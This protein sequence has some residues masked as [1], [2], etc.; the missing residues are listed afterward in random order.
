MLLVGNG[1]VLTLDADM[2]CIENGCVAIRGDGVIV[3]VGRTE[4]LRAAHPDAAFEDARGRVIMPGWINVHQH[5]YSAFAR[6]MSLGGPPQHDFMQVLEGLWWRMDKGL[7]LRDVTD[8]AYVTGI[9]CIRNGVTT[10]FDHH[11]SPFAAEGSLFAIGEVVRALGLRASLAIEVSDRDGPEIARAEIDENLAWLDACRAA[12]SDRLKGLF[13]L[14]ALFTL[15]DDT[16]AYC[17]ERIDPRDGY[18]VHVAEGVLDATQSLQAHQMQ[19]TERLDRFGILRPNTLAVHCIAVT[20]EGLDLLAARDVCVAHNPQSN[21]NNAAG[22]ARILDM[23]RR[24]I[25]AGLGTDGYTNDVLASYKTAPVLQ[26]HCLQDPSV[27]F[28]ETA[29]ML[30]RGNAQIAMRSFE[31]PMGVLAEG[32]LGDVI[33]VD[34]DPPTPIRSDNQIGHILFGIDGR[35]TDT[36]VVGGRVLMRDRRIECVDA[37]RAYARARETAASLWKRL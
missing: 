17:A 31:R 33:I 10:F 22:C 8:S 19:V 11:A 4:A 35:M 29:D 23:K 32:A 34:Y 18:H 6:G 3:A 13:G 7:T 26:R 5:I 1:L 25:L 9:D 14:H 28:M 2:R 30:L 36:T 16:L 24:G 15:G 21:M 37:E 20:D 12:P 27:A